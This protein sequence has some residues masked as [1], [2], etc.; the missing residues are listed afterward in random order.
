ML[1]LHCIPLVRWIIS[2][3]AAH[4]RTQNSQHAAYSCVSKPIRM[5]SAFYQSLFRYI[6]S[7]SRTEREQVALWFTSNF[8]LYNCLMPYTSDK[9]LSSP[10]VLWITIR[11][12]YWF[13][14]RKL[15]IWFENLLLRQDD[16]NGLTFSFHVIRCFLLDMTRSFIWTLVWLQVMN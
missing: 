15:C 2:V 14:D 11:I 5:H 13:V 6:F 3:D 7:W 8:Y 16:T 12:T 10:I 4:K 1:A 9:F